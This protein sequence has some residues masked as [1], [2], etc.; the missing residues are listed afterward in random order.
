VN[1]PKM[2]NID[3]TVAEL[4]A[5]AFFIK[6]CVQGQATWPDVTA[7]VFALAFEVVAYIADA[8]SPMEIETPNYDAQIKSLEDDIKNLRSALALKRG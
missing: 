8:F 1:L 5:I 2:P 6:I 3:L 4:I 7:L